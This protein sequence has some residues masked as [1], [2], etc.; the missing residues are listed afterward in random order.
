MDQSKLGQNILLRFYFY[1]AS[2]N[3]QSQIFG[4]QIPCFDTGGITLGLNVISEGR[5]S[6]PISRSGK[7]IRG[8]PEHLPS[9]GRQLEE[10]DI[11]ICS[12]VQAYST[13]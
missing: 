2:R 1:M 11:K 8:F 4:K 7:A 12:I 3:D 9:S 5:Y 6:G 13:M 10:I